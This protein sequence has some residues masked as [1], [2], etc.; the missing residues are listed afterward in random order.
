MPDRRD[1]KNRTVKEAHLADILE[2]VSKLEKANKLP[3][4]AVRSTDLHLVPRLHPEE[5]NVL[6]LADRVGQLEDTIASLREIVDQTAEETVTIKAILNNSRPLSNPA[7]APAPPLIRVTPEVNTSEE[8]NQTAPAGASTSASHAATGATKPPKTRK[9]KDKSTDQYDISRSSSLS[10]R[11]TIIT[12]DLLSSLNTVQPSDTQ[13]AQ[14]QLPPDQ[15]KRKKRREKRKII[16]GS[17]S[18]FLSL[19]G[20]P[21]PNRDLY[22]SNINKSSKEED[23]TAFVESHGAVVR[24]TEKMSPDDWSYQAFRLTVSK[25]DFDQLQ[26]ADIWPGRITV[27]RY[28]PPAKPKSRATAETEDR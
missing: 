7:P 17:G 5:L 20:G 15:E 8:P 23:I 24:R 28:Y 19:S 11:P 4:I 21:G 6:S 22:I 10:Q 1:G 12:G 14:F 3:C 2:A 27:R 25:T 16:T 9:K 18:D 13:D 26:N